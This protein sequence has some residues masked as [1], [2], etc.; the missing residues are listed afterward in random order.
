MMSAFECYQQ[1]IA[2]KNHFSQP[3]YD[4]FKYNG[5]TNASKSKFDVRKDK[6]FFEKLAKHK[7]PIGFLVVNLAENNK[8]WI[9]DIVYSEQAADLYAQQQ[10]RIQSLRYLFENELDKLNKQFT[11][12]FDIHNNSHPHVVRLYLQKEISLETLIIILDLTKCISFFDTQLEYDPTWG[13]LSIKIKKY[14]PFIQ[15]DKK[16]F[17]KIVV[18]KFNIGC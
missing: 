16:K 6:L 12:N 15:Y 9:R 1:Y 5:K 13:P 10:K 7:D 3:S 2:L 8:A 17:K 11:T 14:T 4:Y 18:D